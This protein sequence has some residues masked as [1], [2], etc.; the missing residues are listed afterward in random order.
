MAIKQFFEGLKLVELPEKAQ[1]YIKSDILT[2][3]DIDLLDTDDEDFIEVKN[4]IEENFPEALVKEKQ[5]ELPVKPTESVLKTQLKIAKK[6]YEKDPSVVYKTQIKIIE[7]MLADVDRFCGGGPVTVGGVEVVKTKDGVSVEKKSDKNKGH[8]FFD[9][10]G[11]GYKCLGYS[12][13]LDD[14]VFLRLS[15]EVEVVGC[16]KG[17]FYNKPRMS[18]GGSIPNN[19]ENKSVAVVW[20]QWNRKQRAH[21]LRDHGFEDS[22]DLLNSTYD[23]LPQ[24]VK[25]VE[26]KHI[27]EGQYSTGG[28]VGKSFL[29]ESRTIKDEQKP[30]LMTTAEIK[31]MWE[32]NL[33]DEEGDIKLDEYLDESRYEDTFVPKK[34]PNVQITNIGN[35]SLE[36]YIEERG[37]S[38]GGAV[39]SVTKDQILSVL[40]SNPF[41]KF[42]SDAAYIL[43]A[44]YD[45]IEGRASDKEGRDRIAN[46]VADHIMKSSDNVK[47]VYLKEIG[48]KMSSTEK[49]KEEGVDLFEDHENIPMNVKSIINLY[50]EA[51]EDGDYK[52]LKKA[53]SRLKKIGYTFEFDLDG[54]A[55]DLRKIGQKGKVK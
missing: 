4:L 12:E 13:Q 14:C 26:Y 54:Q 53:Q 20:E 33:I 36:Q 15:D 8:I 46:N 34:F 2:D 17:F 43:S 52:G 44:D 10:E 48:F 6:M 51:F 1:A 37:Y 11:K 50:A 21:F 39:G 32:A 29:F 40:N 19:Y 25:N 41:N 31:K 47:K 28:G 24:K 30:V 49:G 9:E 7:K 35:D 16:V 55:Y 23:N 45:R 22:D 27:V 38:T 3:A 5:P 18:G 42:V